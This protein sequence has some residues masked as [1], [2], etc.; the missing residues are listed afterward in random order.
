MFN[1][2]EVVPNIFNCGDFSKVEEIGVIA[3]GKSLG[4]IGR[5]KKH[6]KNVFVAGQCLN[7]FE[8]IGKHL[9]GANIVRS[10]G[11]T[12]D[13]PGKRY[14]KLYLEYNIRDIQAALD[15]TVSERKAHKLKKLQKA[16][17]DV[18]TVH[19]CPEHM[20]K[21]NYRYIKER[22]LS[23]GRTSYP[24]LGIQ[25]VDFA[26]IYKPKSVHIIGLDFYCAPYLTTEKH[27]ASLSKNARRAN[28]MIEFFKLLCKAE[29][30]IQFYLYT[31]CKKI[32][33][34]GNLKVIRV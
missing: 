21:R 14:K 25:S 13:R 24:T 5:F 9:K 1:E 12:Y 17:K 8:M 10:W 6:F 16:H 30:D 19:A 11:N 22:K 15:P 27:Q 34:K 26:C 29:S 7:S 28:S 23:R 2:I 31:C 18:L 33:S 32:K 20:R 3:R 4:Q